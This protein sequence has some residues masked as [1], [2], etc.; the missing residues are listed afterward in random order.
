MSK[1]HAGVRQLV[2]SRQFV[3]RYTP[4]EWNHKMIRRRAKTLDVA[5]ATCIPHTGARQRRA[6]QMKF[7]QS[8][9]CSYQVVCR[10]VCTMSCRVRK[11]KFVFSSSRSARWGTYK[12]PSY[13]RGGI[14]LSGVLLKPPRTATPGGIALRRRQHSTQEKGRHM[15]HERATG[16]DHDFW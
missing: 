16:L 9:N 1:S 8:A 13:T 12:Q 10:L 14:L 7:Q 2:S 5:E 3:E 15:H 11:N 4:P 6:T